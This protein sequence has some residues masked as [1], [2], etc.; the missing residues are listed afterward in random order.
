M[1]FKLILVLIFITIFEFVSG[2]EVITKRYAD[3]E[4]RETEVYEG[5]G[6]D[7]RL[8]AKY[9]YARDGNIEDQTIYLE[10]GK[11]KEYVFYSNGDTSQIINYTEGK[12]D[13]EYIQYYEN[14]N[15]FIK[16]QYKMEKHDGIWIELYNNNDTISKYEFE[17]GKW[18]FRK[19]INDPIIKFKN[20][21][22][23]LL[24]KNRYPIDIIYPDYP[25]QILSFK[26]NSGAVMLSNIGQLVLIPWKTGEYIIYVSAMVW[27]NDVTSQ[28]QQIDQIKFIVKE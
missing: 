13:G 14:G 5:E 24:A 6:N 23:T 2:Q 22:D 9:S 26:C 18:N 12:R 11:S 25:N 16:G 27:E 3:G 20:P 1:V 17:N 4:K 15:I 21:V 7:K 28:H 10:N 19:P 8:I